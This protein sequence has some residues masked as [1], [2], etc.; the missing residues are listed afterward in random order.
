MIVVPR[1]KIFSRHIFYF[2]FSKFVIFDSSFSFKSKFSS[3]ILS[4]HLSAKMEWKFLWIFEHGSRE[5]VQLV[6][7]LKFLKGVEIRGINFLTTWKLCRF[8]HS[9]GIAI[10]WTFLQLGDSD[11]MKKFSNRLTCGNII[12]EHEVEENFDKKNRRITRRPYSF[13]L[14]KDWVRNLAII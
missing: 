10:Q 13:S 7:V 1:K 9:L 14:K 12:K 4:S 8:F 6:K 2:P 3:W 11:V 5:N